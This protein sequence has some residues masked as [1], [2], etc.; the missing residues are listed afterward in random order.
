[1]SIQTNTS[2]I[3]IRLSRLLPLSLFPYY[4]EAFKAV[5]LPNILRE[6]ERFQNYLNFPLSAMG[7]PRAPF[8]ARV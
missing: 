8:I 3:L 4:L 6:M 7:L 1:M 2:A 5:G